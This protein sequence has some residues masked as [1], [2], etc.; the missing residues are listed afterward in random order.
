MFLILSHEVLYVVN[1]FARMQRVVDFV[2]RKLCIF[3]RVPI[4]S[5]LAFFSI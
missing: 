1:I 4:T 3:A 5:L 2:E